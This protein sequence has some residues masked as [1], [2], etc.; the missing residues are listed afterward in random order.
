MSNSL[1]N[2]RKF[3]DISCLIVAVMSIVW[4]FDHI[5]S[6][7]PEMG[8]PPIFEIVIFFIYTISFFARSGARYW[9]LF[10]A[11]AYLLFSRGWDFCSYFTYTSGEG[12]GL[13]PA[14]RKASPEL[15]GA[16]ALFGLFAMSLAVNAI[17]YRHWV[18]SE[19]SKHSVPHYD[20]R[21]ENPSIDE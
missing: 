5:Y 3:V 14:I 11:S 9:S 12:I 13:L 20:D 16:V 21:Y 19:N 4:D 1:I 6:S 17:S 7:R 8:S 2:I 10:V 18:R 15:I